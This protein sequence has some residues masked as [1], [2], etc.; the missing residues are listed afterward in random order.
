MNN[1][2]KPLLFIMTTSLSALTL[3]DTVAIPAG[4]Q[5]SNQA[6]AR[7]TTGLS[8]DQVSQRFG[9]PNE[10]LAAIGNPPITRWVYSSYTVY[11][12]K[13]RVIHSVLHPD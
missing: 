8:M 2:L 3:A 12:E 9:A 13:D 10:K 5:G 11:F 4:Q 7:P 1:L 6:I